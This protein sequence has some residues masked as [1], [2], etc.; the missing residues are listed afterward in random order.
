MQ[1]LVPSSCGSMSTWVLLSGR[2]ILCDM[3]EFGRRN[4]EGIARVRHGGTVPRLYTG[5]RVSE[6]P[7]ALGLGPEIY[8]YRGKLISRDCVR[9]RETID[10]LSN[11]TTSWKITRRECCD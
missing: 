3:R 10:F 8:I 9:G 4:I 7:K 5:N 11:N 6:T 1:D 2:G